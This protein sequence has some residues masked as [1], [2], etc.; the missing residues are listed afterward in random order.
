MNRKYIFSSLI[1]DGVLCLFIKLYLASKLITFTQSFDKSY[2]MAQ[3]SSKNLSFIGENI[4]KIRLAKNISQ[5]DFA[6][7]FDLA[8]AS[9]GAYE[10]GRSEPKIETIIQ[11]ANTF[12]LSIDVLLKRELSVS[13]IY[14]MSTVN[15]KLNKAHRLVSG[16][17]K[18]ELSKS[19]SFLKKEA[20]V[21]YLVRR[22]NQSFLNDLPKISIPL[23]T[24]AS[25][26]AFEVD[27]N[28]MRYGGQ[29]LFNRDILIGEKVDQLSTKLEGE[30][31]AL[32]TKNSLV[33]RRVKQ[34]NDTSALLQADDPTYEEMEIAS[35]EVVEIWKGVASFAKQLKGPSLLE[36]RVMKLEEKLNSLG[37]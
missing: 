5:A 18:T 13:E 7:L 10:E 21:E 24:S 16:A 3:K 28:A 4:K 19:V 12:S 30:V 36:Q 33:I 11:I 8:R 17:S 1:P 6:K 31:V 2:S 14:S 35:E 23:V 26:M 22:E 27:G 32:V 20:I 15:E 9:V 34:V 29:G 37:K 25:L